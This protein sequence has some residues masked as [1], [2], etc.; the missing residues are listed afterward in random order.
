MSMLSAFQAQG[1]W[2]KANL[3]THTTLS[4]GSLTPEERRDAYQ[5][6]GYDVLALT[7]HNLFTSHT[8]LSTDSILLLPGSELNGVN[9]PGRP[10]YHVVA[11]G[12]T[13]LPRL[14]VS[15]CQELIEA[16]HEV[17]GVAILAHPY[18]CGL[19]LEDMAPLRGYLGIEVFNTTCLT[20]I[21]KGLSSAHWD[22][23][24]AL[25]ATPLGFAVDDAHD[26][27]R[28][29][30]QGWTMIKAHDLTEKAVLEALRNGACY[31]STG[32]VIHDVSLTGNTLQVNC[33]PVSYINFICRRSTGKHV[34]AASPEGICEAS[35]KLKEGLGYVRIECVDSEGRSAWTQPMRLSQ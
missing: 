32:P 25:G 16:I 17:N 33:S 29:V 23:L 14:E 20:G 13:D 1:S 2:Y 21:G 28:D 11:L 9:A 12:I 5:K 7:D 3:H 35:F 19:T 10:Q 30:F 27:E 22:N 15:S 26:K 8:H 4:D 34:P 6:V 31:A 18:W 24:L